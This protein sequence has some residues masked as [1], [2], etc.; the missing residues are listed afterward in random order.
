MLDYWALKWWGLAI[1]LEYWALKW[2][3]LASVGLLGS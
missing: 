3:G 1:V 2:W